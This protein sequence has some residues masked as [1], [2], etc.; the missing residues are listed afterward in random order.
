MSTPIPRR[1]NS[2][3]VQRRGREN[4]A[5][6]FGGW[7]W[8]RGTDAFG[9]PDAI[10]RGCSLHTHSQ[11]TGDSSISAAAVAPNSARPSPLRDEAVHT[12]TRRGVV[13]RAARRCCAATR[14]SGVGPGARACMLCRR[15]GTRSNVQHTRARPEAS[16]RY[17]RGWA[18]SRTHPAPT[19]LATA[20]AR[21]SILY[22]GVAFASSTAKLFTRHGRRWACAP[23]H[24]S[25]AMSFDEKA[26]CDKLARFSNT[27]QSIERR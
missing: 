15:P 19:R 12:G 1:G 23:P 21:S 4:R 25:T 3:A 5:G 17:R 14:S 9:S 13:T 16:T 8:W 2:P 7:L 27:Q 26:L 20:C 18:L 10:V 24:H 22:V 6:S 11:R